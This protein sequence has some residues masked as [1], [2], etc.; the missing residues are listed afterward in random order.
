[1]SDSAGRDAD[2]A[3]HAAADPQP[4]MVR[5]PLNG[6]LD[7]LTKVMA[8]VLAMAQTRL[9]LLTTEVQEEIRR[10]AGAL[11]WAFVALFAAGIGLFMAA[12]A[13]VFVFWDSHRVLVS[14]LVTLM[15]FVV[16]LVAVWRLRRMTRSKPRLLDAT[17]S[18][19]QQDRTALEERLRSARRNTSGHS[20]S[21]GRGSYH[22]H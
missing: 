8:T 15:F 12:L 9:E 18:E 7:S 20:E 11:L 13:L 2:H 3:E 4:E 5:G 16:A 21:G 19:L 17:L 1:M 6:L 14:V 10:G 22:E